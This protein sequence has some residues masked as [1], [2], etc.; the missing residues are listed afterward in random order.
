M[1]SSQ[2]PF[3]TCTMR[4][5]C[6]YKGDWTGITERRIIPLSLWGAYIKPNSTW[7]TEKGRKT[8]FQP[9]WTESSKRRKLCTCRR[10]RA[11]E[12]ERKRED[13]KGAAISERQRG[14]VLLA[15]T[16]HEL[17]VAYHG[18]GHSP[19]GCVL[20]SVRLAVSIDLGWASNIHNRL[21]RATSN[22]NHNLIRILQNQ[23]SKY[24]FNQRN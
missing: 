4:T 7:E 10:K 15:S 8:M 19:L 11:S 2:N 5:F 24:V 1:A 16:L 23:P 22:L 17:S 20:S 9:A 6:E 14:S 3:G 21:G 13:L 18:P 12:R